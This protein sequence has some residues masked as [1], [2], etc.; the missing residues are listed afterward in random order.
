MLPIF[1]FRLNSH[2][3]YWKIQTQNLIDTS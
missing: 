3:K 1:K 2:S